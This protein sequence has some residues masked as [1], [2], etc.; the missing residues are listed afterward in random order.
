LP[1]GATVRTLLDYEAMVRGLEEA[2][3]TEA[4]GD[5]AQ[6]AYHAL[7]FGWLAGGMLQHAVARTT[8]GPR[9]SF[10]EL[11]E[12]HLVRPLN[13][14]GQ[15]FAGLP[16]E[17]SEVA[18]RYCV[19]ERL[20]ACTIQRQQSGA[21][22]A[23]ARGGGGGEGDL[24]DQLADSSADEGGVA[25]DPRLFNDPSV[26][27]ANLP[28]ANMH[29]TSHALATVYSALAGGAAAAP[30]LPPAFCDMLLREA[31][32]ATRSRW[33][34]GFATY[35]SETGASGFGFNGLW[36][37]CGLC[38]PDRRGGLAVAVLV[39]TYTPTAEAAT[40]VLD[41]VFKARGYGGIAGH[42]LGGVSFADEGRE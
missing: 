18:T 34:L 10:G 22:Q 31:R 3:Q 17:G 23:G 15:L 21:R 13:L 19:Y 2:P 12:E 5:A 37:S 24:F 32:A 11:L 30:L 39:N 33:P 26:R 27:R 41:H 8:G 14:E 38:M 36:N 4:G 20:A 9:P 35:R 7:S 16:P 29:F 42:A 6:P 25:L 28:A 40:R 1:E